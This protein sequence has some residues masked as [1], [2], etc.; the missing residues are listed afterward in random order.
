M[1]YATNL[2][3]LRRVSKILNLRRKPRRFRKGEIFVK[4]L[5]KNLHLNLATVG[6]VFANLL[7]LATLIAISQNLNQREEAIAAVDQNYENLQLTEQIISLASKQAISL[8]QFLHAEN[9]SQAAHEQMQI[10]QQEIATKLAVLQVNTNAVEIT[11]PFHHVEL[12]FTDLFRIAEQLLNTKQ[13]QGEVAANEFLAHSNYLNLQ[14][15]I[16]NELNNLKEKEALKLKDNQQLFAEKRHQTRL[17]MIFSAIAGTL[18]VTLCFIV[19]RQ[20]SK[21]QQS[22]QRLEQAR[23]QILEALIQ[24]ADLETILTKIAQIVETHN[25]GALVSILLLQDERYLHTIAAPSLPEFY[26][27]AINGL[28]IGMG[29]GSCGTAAFTKKRVIVENLHTH[30]YW[31]AFLPVTKPAKLGSCWSQP[32]VSHDGKVVATFAIYHRNPC[33][34][35]PEDLLLIDQV[36]RLI[37]IAIEK[38]QIIDAL[39]QSESRFQE[40]IDILPIP[41]LLHDAQENVKFVNPA[42]VQTLGYT[43]SDIP[44]LALWRSKT[45]IDKHGNCSDTP[46]TNTTKEVVL[47]CL[48]RSQKTLLQT[49]NQVEP[50]YL[51]VFHDITERKKIEQLFADS[52]TQLIS[53]LEAIP[54]SILFKDAQ[55]RWLIVNEPTKKLLELDGIDWQNKTDLELA[56]LQPEFKL[57]Y[58]Q[59]Y[60]NDEKIWQ[61][62][63]PALF[64]EQMPTKTG[65]DLTLEVR[66]VPIFASDGSPRALLVITRDITERMLFEEELQR[67]KLAADEANQAKSNFL[68]NM[69]H[70]IRTPLNAVI[71]FSYLISQTPLQPKQ[72]D[73]VEKIKQSGTNLLGLINDILDISKIEAGKLEIEI[74]PFDLFEVI[75]QVSSIIEARIA[76]KTMPLKFS[77][78]IDAPQ[79][80]ISDAL[81]LN[82]VLLNLMTN[83]VKFTEQGEITLSAKVLSQTQN[84]VKLQFSV[85]DTGIGI[86]AEAI[87]RLFQPFSQADS[88]TSRRYGGTGLGLN[89]CKRLVEM[90]GGKISVTSVLGEGSC[91]SFTAEFNLCQVG[92]IEL[93]EKNNS[94]S[95]LANLNILLVD[96][97]K[98]E[99][100]IT[101]ELLQKFGVSVDIASSG[102]EAIALLNHPQNKIYDGIFLDWKMP[103]MDGYETAQHIINDIDQNYKS[104]III[105]TAYDNQLMRSQVQKLGIRRFVSKPVEISDL[106]NT[107]ISL[108]SAKNLLMSNHS[109]NQQALAQISHLQPA[110]I[111]LVEDNEVN[112]EIVK[113]LLANYDVTIDIASNGL[114]A[115]EKVK[116][117]PYQLVFMDIQMPKMDGFEATRIIREELGKKELPIIAMTAHAM[118]TEVDKCLNSGMNDHLSKPLSPPQLYATLLKWVA[119]ASENATTR[120]SSA[121]PQEKFAGL[122]NILD[123]EKGL[124]H[125]NNNHNLYHKLLKN[126]FTEQTLLLDELPKLAQDKDALIRKVHTLKSLSASLGID[127]LSDC[128][129]QLEQNLINL[130]E[131]QE[132]SI[133]PLIEKLQGV[134]MILKVWLDEN[135]AASDSAEKRGAFDTTGAGRLQRAPGLPVRPR[136]AERGDERRP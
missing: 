112:Q 89:I 68:A 64:T 87:N 97:E 119:E 7:M 30:P 6:L 41:V 28:E 3:K 19:L 36:S 96:D 105:I 57:L 61:S 118:K 127:E 116:N 23:V 71:N 31:K 15:Q 26:K 126:F 81:R 56:T 63:K 8:H 55:G 40:M 106:F 128:A 88:S 108:V 113:E 69:S 72:K 93:I 21:M 77:C 104:K 76:E 14:N 109:E 27:E 94:S 51:K 52:N 92:D 46:E 60:V 50:F 120:D 100:E 123:A 58:T 82:Q 11:Q 79:Y 9:L 43:L 124:F 62:G 74:A 103:K 122:K 48:D 17:H 33:A 80:L 131:A 90:M 67:S 95:S 111:L 99:Q 39:H 135:A 110:R 20:K 125:L 73:Y 53:L 32:I 37:G 86:S 13:A 38:T 2:N 5:L 49:N 24:E 129:L 45:E 25:Q 121:A 34:P 35:Q 134:L 70:E 18:L 66:K 130:P 44:T 54:D 42:F 91:F 101:A 47:R 1:N 65:S 29:V 136:L 84:Q 75:A 16:S 22:S 10:L 85:Q 102:E 12:L 98:N 114:E 133:D 78:Q 107:I 4:N 132:L 115:V 117:T 83:A 59:C